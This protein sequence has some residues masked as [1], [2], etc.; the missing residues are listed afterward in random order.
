MPL[1]IRKFL[2]RPTNAVLLAQDGHDPEWA[3]FNLP[4]RGDLQ[5]LLSIRAEQEQH[6]QNHN[7][8]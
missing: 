3:E 4:T 2:L 5:A 1:W 6:A 7:C 8:A